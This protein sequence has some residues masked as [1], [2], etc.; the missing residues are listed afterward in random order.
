MQAHANANG[1]VIRPGFFSEHMLNGVSGGNR[2]CGADENGKDVVALSS[3]P[4]DNAMMLL[5][6]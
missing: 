1:Y 5:D 3:A 6:S 4:D 2:V